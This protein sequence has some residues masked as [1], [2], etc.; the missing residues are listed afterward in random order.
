MKQSWF[1][2]EAEQWDDKEIL[3]PVDESYHAI[4]VLRVAPPDVI[5]ITDGRGKVAKVSVTRIDGDRVA[6]EI[7]EAED[8]R[9]LKP[10][11]VVY[12]GAAKGQKVD[13]AIERLAELGVAEVWVYESQRS[14][15]HWNKEKLDRLS[16]RWR[17]IARSASKQSRNPFML[18]T[19]GGLSW[20]QLLRRVSQEPCAVVLW[21]EGALPLRTALIEGAERVA[22]VVGPEGGLARNE[23]EA[24][25]DAGCQVVSLGPLILRTENAPVVAAAA[26]LY[27]YGLIG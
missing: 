24:L 9:R 22:L 27:H 5:T 12:Q 18:R 3:L 21:E 15:V 4:K 7:L 8:R 25:A 19:G 2:V 11:L 1:V 20:T 17:A 14:V 26:V 10:E 23:A 16:R 13:D 6:V